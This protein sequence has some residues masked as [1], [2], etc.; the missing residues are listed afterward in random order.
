VG[1]NTLEKAVRKPNMIKALGKDQ[2][3]WESMVIKER[4]RRKS[5]DRFF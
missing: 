2:S 1:K 3:V 4:G 5:K